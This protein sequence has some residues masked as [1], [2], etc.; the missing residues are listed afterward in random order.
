MQDIREAIRT[1]RG[2]PVTSAVAILSLALGI[3]ASTAIFSIFNSL[4]LKPLPI[5]DP[6]SLIA[7]ASDKPGED[8]AMTYPIWIAVRDSHVLND[9]FVWS[10]DQVALSGADDVRSL[11]T[12]W[13]SGNLFTALGVSA[14]AGRTFTEADDHRGG[15]AD[16]PVAVL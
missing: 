4:L 7:L 12:L 1:L 16:G 13:G 3:G 8:A 9:A 11:A 15:G 10:T 5:R 14:I 2:S 6:G